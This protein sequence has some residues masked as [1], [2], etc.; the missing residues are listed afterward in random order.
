MVTLVVVAFDKV[1]AMDLLSDDIVS[2]FWEV[3]TTRME[4]LENRYG[5]SGKRGKNFTRKKTDDSSYQRF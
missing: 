2:N 5:I 1:L 3:R 4:V